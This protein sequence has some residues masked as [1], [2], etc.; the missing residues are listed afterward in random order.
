[1]SVMSNTQGSDILGWRGGGGVG[2]E[3]ALG[4][5]VLKLTGQLLALMHT[6]ASF[7]TVLG[8]ILLPGFYGMA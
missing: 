2:E 5:S 6:T 7:R 1:M 4:Q 3:V 8:E